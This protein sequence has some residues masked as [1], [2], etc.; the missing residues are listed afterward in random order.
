MGKRYGVVLLFIPLFLIGCAHKINLTPPLNTL[1]LKGINPVGKN[2]GYYISPEDKAK[3]VVTPGGGGDKVKYTP[4][5][6]LEPALKQ[7]LDNIFADVK[8]VESLENKAFLDDNGIS[9]VF[10]PKFT[11]DSSSSSAFTWP[12]TDFSISMSCTAND[13]AGNKV[14]EST[15]EGNGKAEFSEFKHD[16]SLSARRAAKDV[17][18]KFEEEIEQTDALK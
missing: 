16:L 11:T 17:F 12:P 5:A 9:Y 10:I 1:A 6:D 8:P 3:E 14:W 7:A 13:A 15:V 2:V 18:V 4:Y